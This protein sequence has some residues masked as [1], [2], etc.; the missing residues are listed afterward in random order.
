MSGRKRPDVDLVAVTDAG[1]THEGVDEVVDSARRPAARAYGRLAL[2]SRRPL[3]RR[4]AQ[5]VIVLGV[6]VAVA[7]AVFRGPRPGSHPTSPLVPP[8]CA[9]G[10]CSAT[11]MTEAELRHVKVALPGG[12]PSGLRLRDAYNVPVSIE[13]VS[14]DGHGVLTVNAARVS[15]APAGWASET[16]APVAPQGP[17]R[18]VVRGV[19]RSPTDQ[20]AWAVEVRAII[21]SGY[22]TLV[23][24]ARDLA[25]DGS[26]VA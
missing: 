25:V 26:L 9:T 7:V 8:A 24:A 16:I 17:N 3:F 18:M 23:Q 20:A 2:A 12:N 11:S 6:G 5:V 21:P 4:I 19:V 10:L 1:A 15:H 14:T 13:L 22:T